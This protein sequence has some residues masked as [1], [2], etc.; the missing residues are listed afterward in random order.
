M[1]MIPLA[2][3]FRYGRQPGTAAQRWWRRQRDKCWRC[4]GGR[5]PVRHCLQ[6]F[7]NQSG[8]AVMASGHCGDREAVLHCLSHDLRLKLGRMLHRLNGILISPGNSIISI[9]LDLGEH[10]RRA[11]SP[12]R[13]DGFAGRLLLF[14]K[15][16]ISLA[17]LVK[18]SKV[19]I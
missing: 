11:D 1:L 9:H 16:L 13:Q 19:T 17:A 6:P 14:Y 3:G 2:P 4:R 7:V 10:H 18:P 5:H 15:Q 12:G 8:I